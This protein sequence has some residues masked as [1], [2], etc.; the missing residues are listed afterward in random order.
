M[1]KTLAES[2]NT[3]NLTEA[4]SGTPVGDLLMAY[5]WAK[6]EGLCDGMTMLAK[7]CQDPN[8]SKANADVFSKNDLFAIK[9]SDGSFLLAEKPVKGGDY[10]V[11]Q[12]K[13]SKAEAVFQTT[14]QYQ[15]SDFIVL[16]SDKLQKLAPFNEKDGEEGKE[17]AEAAEDPEKTEEKENS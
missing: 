4:N 3:D 9:Y 13:T 8:A 11:L 7:A 5:I 16:T 17:K 6:G 12:P 2:K 15:I 1:K 14:Q 10:S